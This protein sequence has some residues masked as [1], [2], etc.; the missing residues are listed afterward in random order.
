VRFAYLVQELAA[1]V[2]Y[3]RRRR[4]PKVQFGQI[5]KKTADQLLTALEDELGQIADAKSSEIPELREAVC[6]EIRRIKDWRDPR[7]HARVELE[8]GIALYDWRTRKQLSMTHRECTEMCDLACSMA[9]RVGGLV[10]SLLKDLKADETLVSELA[11]LLDAP[12]GN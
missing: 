9:L 10:G 12:G 4:E 11:I 7:I 2:Y 3:L 6:P 1:A 5:F 8:N